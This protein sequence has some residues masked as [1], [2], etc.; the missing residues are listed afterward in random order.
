MF[1]TFF[2]PEPVVDYETAKKSDVSLY[3]KY[4]HAMLGRGV[5]VAPSQLEAGFLSI[6]H[7]PM[8]LDRTLSAMRDSLRDAVRG[9]N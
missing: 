2:A 4:F 7:G 5:Y 3:A 9:V 8:E 1:G 6:T